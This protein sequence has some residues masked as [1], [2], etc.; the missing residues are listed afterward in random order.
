[1]EEA[2]EH[3]RA[4]SEGRL[5]I[6][7]HATLEEELEAEAFWIQNSLKIV[8]DTHAAGKAA[9]TRSKRWWTAEIKEMRRSFAGARRAYKCG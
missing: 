4:L 1:M 5:L 9:C 6:D 7:P 8:L 2:A 3:W